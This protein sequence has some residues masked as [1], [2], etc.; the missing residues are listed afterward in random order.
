[1]ARAQ[2]YAKHREVVSETAATAGAEAHGRH[3]WRACFALA[4]IGPPHPR[5]PPPPPPKWTDTSGCSVGTSGAVRAGLASAC[6]G[7]FASSLVY[8]RAT[9]PRSPQ[10]AH[11]PSSRGSSCARPLDRV[12]KPSG[13][14]VWLSVETGPFLGAPASFTRTA[15][16]NSTLRSTLEVD[17]RT[18]A[19]TSACLRV[20]CQARRRSPHPSNFAQR[21]WN[22]RTPPPRGWRR[23]R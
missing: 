17:W 19:Y 6:A 22:P 23:C 18:G 1:M 5:P 3:A 12:D 4:F 21:L 13:P 10:E 7:M 16:V 9:V 8:Q 15:V 11:S 2:K 14:Q 20:G